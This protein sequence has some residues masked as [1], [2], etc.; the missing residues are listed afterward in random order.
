[1]S[2]FILIKEKLK[3]NLKQSTFLKLM[4]SFKKKLEDKRLA[5]PFFKRELGT[6]SLVFDLSNRILLEIYEH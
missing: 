3:V 6:L 2:N 5:S 4:F 1:M